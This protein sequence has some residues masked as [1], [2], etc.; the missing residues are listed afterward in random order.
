LRQTATVTGP[1]GTDTITNVEFLAFDDTT[2]AVAPTGG[3]L[4]SGDIT[5]ETINGTV[6]ADII[7][8]MGGQFWPTPEMA[9][10]HKISLPGIHRRRHA[11]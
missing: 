1:D 4:V 8:G 10:D 3:L 6:L 11:R 2:I 9:K 7:G 5:N